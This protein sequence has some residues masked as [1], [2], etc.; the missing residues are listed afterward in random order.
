MK[1]IQK[2]LDISRPTAYALLKRREFQWIR[3]NCGGYRISKVS[4]DEWFE[5]GIVSGD[6]AS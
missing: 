1:E 2:I 5:K 3:L 4:F 6:I